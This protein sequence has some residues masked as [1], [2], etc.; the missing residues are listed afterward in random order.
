MENEQSEAVFDDALDEAITGIDESGGLYPIAKLAAHQSSI[1]HLAIS[2]F[3]FKDG[4]LLLQQRAA[5]KYHAPLL[6]AN[7]AC[8]HPRWGES[9]EACVGRTLRRELG[10][11]VRAIHFTRTHYQAPIGGLFENEVVDCY[12]GEIGR[13]FDPDAVDPRE[14]KSVRFASLESIRQ[15]VGAQPEHFAPWLRIYLATGILARAFQG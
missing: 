13:D 1:R 8:S 9:T 4:E 10:I 3:L 6:W 2:V 7:S 14:V 15:E 11:E 12:R 5:G